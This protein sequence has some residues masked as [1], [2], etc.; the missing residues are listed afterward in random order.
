MLF[1]AFALYWEAAPWLR[2]LSAKRLPEFTKEQ[3]FLAET[4]AEPT[5]VIITGSGPVPAAAALS[6]VLAQLAPKEGDLFANIGSCG[7]PD[8]SVPVG[9]T[10]LIHR[11]LEAATGRSFYPD[12]LYVHSF[13]EHSLTTQALPQREADGP[14]GML[15][16]MEAAALFQA[17]LPFFSTERMFFFKTVSDWGAVSELSPTA[18]LSEAQEALPAIRETLLRFAANQ[19]RGTA[20][21]PEEEARIEEFCRLLCASESMRLEIR[22]LITYYELERGYAIAMVQDF[23]ERHGLRPADGECT[24]SR[25]EGKLYLERFREACLR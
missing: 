22:R 15:Y 8:G 13:P 21:G 2:T 1:L 6:R 12:L 16:D 4:E 5:A 9:R 25:K 24:L 23:I 7:C 14:A 18:L 20:Y 19:Q 3:V 11:L 17:A 10:V